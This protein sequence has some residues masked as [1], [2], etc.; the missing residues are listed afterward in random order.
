MG[1]F[2]PTNSLEWEKFGCFGGF[3]EALM[4]EYDVRYFHD[5]FGLSSSC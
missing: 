1:F 2:K 4:N 3:V 5:T